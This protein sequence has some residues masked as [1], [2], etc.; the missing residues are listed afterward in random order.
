MTRRHYSTKDFFRHVP[1][2]LL[3]RFF[4]EHALFAD[5]DFKTMKE[6]R[7]DML[8]DAWLALDE[9]QRNPIDAQFRKIFEVS[10]P[11]GFK[12]IIGEARWQLRTTPK[13]ITPFVD[14][15]SALPN[16]YHR[17]MTIFLDHK[18]YWKGAT[19]F[20]HADTLTHWRKRQ[21]LGHPP[22]KVDTESLQQ[23]ANQIGDYFH[24]TEGRGK[25]C[26]VEPYRRGELDYF[27]CFPE[28][29][30]QQSPE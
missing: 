15:L 13:Q 9:K 4:N 6:T 17:A 21:H 12:V 28:D 20:Y 23:L 8:F 18:D 3:A 5:L 10:S 2:A 25:H 19:R 27:F 1:N 14:S 29:H 16:H 30:S 11:K 7:P 24:Y 22:A 26:E